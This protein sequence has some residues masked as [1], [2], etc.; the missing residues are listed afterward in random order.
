MSMLEI[1]FASTGIVLFLIAL[2]APIGIVL[3]LVSFGGVWAALGFQ[4]AWGIA[5]AIPFDFIANWS[6]SAVPMF[7]LMGYVASNGGLT[8]GLFAA[9][10][11]ILRRVPGGLG[12]AG[13][14]ACALFSAASGSSVA[15]SAA[16]SRIAVPE[17]LKQG[18][19]KA[20]ATG[21]IA[22]AG[23]LGS[24]I[25][26]SILMIVYAIFANVSV[27]KL[28]LAGFL[29][30]ALSAAMY[31]TMI[32]L[33]VKANPSLAPRAEITATR[34]D[35]IAAL[36]QVWP[37]P[38]LILGVL[39]G[40][41]AGV[42]T[43]TEAGAVGA[44]LAMVLAALRRRLTWT[45]VRTAVRD[46][47]IGTSTVFII[48]VGATMF[49][50][51]MG[52]TGVPRAI[53]NAM[54]SVGDS[55]VVLILMIAVVYIVLG[56]FIESIGIMLL[57][58]PIFF[59]LLQAANVDMI[60]FGIIVI[61]LLEIGMITPPVGL[62]CYVIG[63]ALRGTVPISTVFRGALWFIATDMITLTLLIS[64]PAIALWLPNLLD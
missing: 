19:D 25:P 38:A 55:P 27:G 13:V 12:C 10:K 11:I 37:L 24:L 16:M 23:T 61:K 46:A 57:T 42:M 31:M 8:D 58:L 53:A 49:T 15:T 50:S 60:W 4:V 21:T 39:G 43:P 20:L 3:L 28:F 40:I 47:A 33:R 22:S 51:F 64:F 63:S 1:G 30:G 7:L 17:M 44:S 35:T 18:Y 52:L 54:L 14:G 41:F 48:A 34:A 45:V 62:N 2:R 6:F 32:M 36:K 59:P 9:L 56:M 5:R 26:P 29:P